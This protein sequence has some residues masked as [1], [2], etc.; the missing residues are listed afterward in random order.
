MAIIDEI[1]AIESFIQA[2][3]PESATGKQTI[4]KKP[5]VDTFYIR[6]LNDDRTT[7][8]RYHYRADREY[9]VIYFAQWPEEVIPK[10][11][12][13][14]EALYQTE[15]IASGI[16]VESFAFAQPVELDSGGYVSIG[17]LEVAVRTARQQPDDP[18]IEQIHI[19]QV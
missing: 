3:F 2:N 14:S 7:E 9:Q 10:M 11:D 16:R 18:L 13:L 12:A 1:G 19:R 8:T 5:I 17:I 6:F 15:N 4:P